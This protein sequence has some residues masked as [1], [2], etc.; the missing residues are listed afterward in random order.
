MR[1]FLFTI[2]FLTLFTAM[3]QETDTIYFDSFEL[4]DDWTYTDVGDWTLIDLDEENQ[5]GITG[6]SFPD[7]IGHPFAA[8]IINS[9]EA[10]PVTAE[11][12]IPDLRNYE[13]RTRHKVLGMFAALMPANDDWVISPQIALGEEE[14][15]LTFYVKSAYMNNQKHEKFEVLISTTDTEP[16]SF[17]AFPPVYDGDYFTN[18]EWTEIAIDLD[19]Y[20]NQDVYIAIHYISEIYDNPQFPPHLQKRANALL[21]D[22]FLVTT[23]SMMATNDFSNERITE[24]YPNPFKDILTLSSNEKIQNIEI[25]D[26]TGKLVY[27]QKLSAQ[28]KNINLSF[29]NSGVYLIKVQNTTGV[30]V[31]KVVKK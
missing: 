12:N 28:Q 31:L 3:G 18:T 17:V 22:D 27:Q 7:N 13:P 8:K 20:S 10:E 29:L 19:E 21:M 1:N 14:N 6:V 16:D 24:V 4:Y 9:S 25:Y 11:I 23:K 30:Q 26:L 2:S 15:K 5:M